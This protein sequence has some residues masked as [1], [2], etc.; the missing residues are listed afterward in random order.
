MPNIR[1]PFVWNQVNY[2]IT[3]DTIRRK[4]LLPNGIVL[5]YNGFFFSDPPEIR[6][7]TAHNFTVTILPGASL[8]SVAK[9]INAVLAV[10]VGYC[11]DHPDQTG[12]FC[13]VC[14]RK[15][16]SSLISDTKP[17]FPIQSQ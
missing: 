1:V 6:E 5:H 13:S 16:T 9:D 12:N 10:E 14:G 15:I 2:T 11:L 7:L 8:A 17:P 4:I 3:K